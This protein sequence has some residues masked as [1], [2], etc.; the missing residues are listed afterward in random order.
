MEISLKLITVSDPSILR[1]IRHIRTQAYSTKAIEKDPTKK[2]RKV[3]IFN[4]GGKVFNAD[5]QDEISQIIL[6][7]RQSELYSL[8]FTEGE[9]YTDSK[10]V[11]QKGI[12]FSSFLTKKQRQEDIDFE[13]ELIISQS[14][15]DLHIKREEAKI[16]MMIASIDLNKVS[17]EDLEKAKP[18]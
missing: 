15:G 1:A 10:G 2:D 12:N 8:S 3:C 17:I 4:V 6:G 7:K 13:Q 14:K 9:D 18:F 5:E 11:T 16:K